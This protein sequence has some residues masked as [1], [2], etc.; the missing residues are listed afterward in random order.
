M[1]TLKN[2]IVSSLFSCTLLFSINMPL[3]GQNKNNYIAKNSISLNLFEEIGIASGDIDTTIFYDTTLIMNINF[4]NPAF[5]FNANQRSHHEIELSRFA[6]SKNEVTKTI[7]HNST[8]PKGIIQLYN[9]NLFQLS[10]A[11]FYNHRLSSTEKPLVFYLSTG[12]SYST[13]SSVK[14]PVSEQIYPWFTRK[15]NKHQFDVLL[16]PK[17]MYHF[18]SKFI[19]DISAGISVYQYYTYSNTVEGSIFTLQPEQIKIKQNDFLAH[20]FRMSIGIGYTL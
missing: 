13:N 14:N 9:E 12:V 10:I 4:I 2:F 7:Q 6:F 11:Y 18:K 3:F 20:L 8:I 15:N 5:I 19:V 16:R 17:V 1:G